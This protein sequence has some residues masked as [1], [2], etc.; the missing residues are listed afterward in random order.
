PAQVIKLVT[1]AQHRGDA[2]RLLLELQRC[3]AQR[4]TI[5]LAMGPEGWMTRVLARK[6]GAFLTFATLTR[7]AESAPG[8][9]T[10]DELRDTFRWDAQNP[11]TAVYGVAGWPIAHSRS[12]QLHNAALAGARIDAVYLPFLVRPAEA[13]FFEFMDAADRSAAAPLQG[14][15]VTLP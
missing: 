10:L 11:A 1:T 8:Q 2:E 13:D 12:P 5:M 15:S 3:A 7:G 9:P 6:F 14:L 4:C